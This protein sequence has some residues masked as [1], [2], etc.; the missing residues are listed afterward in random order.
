MTQKFDRVSH[1]VCMG[2]D[3]QEIYSCS[4]ASIKSGFHFGCVCK[5]VQESFSCSI[6]SIKSALC[7]GVA[8]GPH[9][10]QSE[11]KFREP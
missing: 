11:L 6:A 3:K 2:K 10:Q 4:F 5:D 7:T 1:V 8:T 9:V